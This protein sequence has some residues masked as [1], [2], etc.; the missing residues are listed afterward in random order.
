MPQNFYC[1]DCRVVEDESADS[2]SLINTLLGMAIDAES[3]KPMLSTIA[4][5]LSVLLL[6]LLPCVWCGK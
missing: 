6:S 5:G 2:I 4:G 1:R 3:R